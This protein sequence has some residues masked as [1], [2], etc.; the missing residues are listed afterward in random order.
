MLSIFKEVKYLYSYD[1]G[2]TVLVNNSDILIDSKPFLIREWFSKGIIS[3]KDLLD[4][5]AS[6]SVI[7]LVASYLIAR[8]IF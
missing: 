6:F 1:L 3:I 7:K 5:N 4:E 2:K 8:R